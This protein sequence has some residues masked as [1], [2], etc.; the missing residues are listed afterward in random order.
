MRRSTRGWQLSGV[1]LGRLTP[2]ADMC[3]RLISPDA[4]LFRHSNGCLFNAYGRV[5]I[6]HSRNV[7]DRA[8]FST[9]TRLLCPQA[10]RRL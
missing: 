5:K 3:Y 7:R 2:F 10:T 6:I 9:P 8:A 4:G 1:P